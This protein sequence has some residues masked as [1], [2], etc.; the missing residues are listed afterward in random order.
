MQVLLAFRVSF[1]KSGVS[2]IGLLLYVGAPFSFQLLI[3]F[4]ALYVLCFDYYV[5]RGHSFLVQV[6]GVLLASC[7]FIGTS[8]FRLGKFSSMILLK[9]FSGPLSRNSSCYSIS[10]GFRFVFFI[11]SHIFWMSYNSNVIYI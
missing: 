2:L 6:F 5:A 3:S 11:V 1:E 8:L 10:I 4:F 9:I 7:T